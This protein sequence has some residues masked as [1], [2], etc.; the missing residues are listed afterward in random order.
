MYKNLHAQFF[1]ITKRGWAYCREVGVNQKGFSA[2]IITVIG[3]A[4]LFIAVSS[5]L[6]GIGALNEVYTAER[7][8]EAFYVA[9]GCT[10]EALRRLR[11]NASYTGVGETITFP[12]LSASCT[13]TVTDLG[14]GGR[15]I[16]A[17]GRAANGMYERSIQMEITLSGNIITVTSWQETVL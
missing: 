10:E 4:A 3:A 1:C 5:S 13:V 9:D 7:G 8:Y 16:V 15:R 2:L 12:Q 14:S 17:T 6:L 11:L